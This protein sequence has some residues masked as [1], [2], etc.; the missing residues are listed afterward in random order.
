MAEMITKT[1]QSEGAPPV[2]TTEEKEEDFSCQPVVI[3]KIPARFNED[4]VKTLMSTMNAQFEGTDFKVIFAPEEVDIYFL[5]Q[6]LPAKAR[7][8]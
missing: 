4:K 3:V 2:A 1:N 7:W 8:V 5:G 6:D